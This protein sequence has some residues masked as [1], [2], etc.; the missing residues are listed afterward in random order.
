MRVLYHILHP[1]GNSAERWIYEAWRGGFR[2]LGHTVEE[3]R[4]E[5]DFEERIFELRPDVFMTDICLLDLNRHGEILKRARAAQVKVC[6]WMHWPLVDSV[7]HNAVHLVRNNVADL[8]FGERELDHTAFHRDTGKTYVCIPHAANPEFHFPAEPT[9]EFASDVL[10]IG[11]RLP[12]K[13]W[14]ETNVLYPLLKERKHKIKVIGNGWSCK[15]QLLRIGRKAATM[16]RWTGLKNSIER[17][18]VRITAATERLYY[19]SARIS[20][21]FHEREPDGSQPHYIVNQ[22]AFKIPACGGFQI[23]DEVPALRKYFTDDEIILLPLDRERWISTIRYYLEHDAE[24][25]AIRR[26]GVRRAQQDHLATSRCEYL[27]R[28]LGA[29]PI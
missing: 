21:N 4:F 7:K 23:C 18:S 15:D 24:R 8:Y 2:A 26:K 9:N 16:L 28:L 22:R 12:H 27:I 29:D 17:K 25:E 19:S 6:I 5:H 13:K 20:L 14:F 11:S 3:L 10:Y 1:Q